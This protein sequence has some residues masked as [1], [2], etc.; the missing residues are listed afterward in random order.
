MIHAFNCLSFPKKKD[1][2]KKNKEKTQPENKKQRNYEHNS[3]FAEP[4]N[5]FW[6][7]PFV[8]LN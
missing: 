2:G 8:F 1:C 3:A 7:T 4:R 5:C 6:D